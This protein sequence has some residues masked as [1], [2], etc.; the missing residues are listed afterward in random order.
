MTED[1]LP[2]IPRSRTTRKRLF[3]PALSRL[4]S[5]PTE[6]P[7]DDSA[8]SIRIRLDEAIRLV[9]KRCEATTELAT[10]ARRILRILL[11]ACLAT[12]GIAAAAA[13]LASEQ[14]AICLGVAGASILAGGVLA[15]TV[16]ARSADLA[17][18]AGLRARY[19]PLLDRCETVSEL[20]E[21]SERLGAE[22][23]RIA[24]DPRSDS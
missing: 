9:E 23:A 10:R 13:F 22:M 15:V 14:L 20:R 4:L 5:D 19:R 24:V 11:G 6:L 17:S 3:V 1:R 18:L 8:D 2:P 12:A 16:A 7:L 21:L